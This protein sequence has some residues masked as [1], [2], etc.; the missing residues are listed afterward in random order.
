[1][2]YGT[3]TKNQRIERWWRELV[4]RQ[5]DQWICYFDELKGEGCFD[6]SKYD[7]IALQ[8]LFMD[9]IRNDISAFVRMYNTHPIRTQKA[10]AAYLP[11]GKPNNMYNYPPDGSRNY[12]SPPDPNLL[13]EIEAQLVWYDDTAYLSPATRQLCEQITAQSGID[14]DPL[15]TQPGLDTPYTQ[16]Y[17]I[18]RQRLYEHEAA[19]GGEVVELQT[20]V[21]GINTI[22]IMVEQFNQQSIESATG[23]V[24]EG[25][26]EE[27]LAE[28]ELEEEICDQVDGDEEDDGL[29]FE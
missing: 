19:G 5:T 6:G 13:A 18:L 29:F 21:G 2:A 16:L 3:S 11:T 24:L 8:F 12:S 22:D 9:K 26:L 15:S 4:D 27:E 23:G 14:Y 7:R 17:L 25:E 20:P 1:M 28:G 10:R